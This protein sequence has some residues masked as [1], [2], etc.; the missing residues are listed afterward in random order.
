MDVLMRKCA[1]H[2]QQAAVRG[3]RACL[4][5]VETST[6]MLQIHSGASSSVPSSPLAS[7]MVALPGG[8][9]S[10]LTLDALE[11]SQH[12]RLTLSLKSTTMKPFR[13]NQVML[14][15]T[16]PVGEASAYFV[17]K[18]TDVGTYIFAVTCSQLEEQLGGGR[19]PLFVALSAI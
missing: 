16:P 11:R 5:T 3:E 7:T 12:L 19:A 9:A 18:M 15:V 10:H 13:A 17:G 6:V 2:H 1:I 14:R 8:S 4:Q